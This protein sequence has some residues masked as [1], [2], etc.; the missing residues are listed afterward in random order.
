MAAVWLAWQYGKHGFKKLVAIKTILPKYAAEPGFQQMFLDECR[1]ASGIQHA[2][3]TQILDVG[4]AH[5]VLYMVMEW[6]D[7]DSLLKVE[8]ALRKTAP[9]FP[10]EVLLRIL[11]DA[12]LGLHA[13]H[14]LCDDRGRALGVVHRDV[15][16]Q[17]LLV[18]VEG[19]TKLI[20]FG[21]VKARDR[22]LR[23]TTSGLVKGKLQY[24]APEQALGQPVSR[25]A[26]IWAIGA[27]FYRVVKGRPAY[28][29]SNPMHTMKLVSSRRLPEPLTPQMGVHRAVL[30]VI[31]VALSPNPADRYPTALEMHRALEEAMVKAGQRVPAASVAAFLETHLGDRAAARRRAVLL[32]TEAASARR[33]L[34][35]V[36]KSPS[37]SSNGMIAVAQPS[38]DTPPPVSSDRPTQRID[39]RELHGSTVG[40]GRPELTAAPRDVFESIAGTP[41]SPTTWSPIRW[42]AI[43]FL[44]VGL[45]ALLLLRG[46][47]VD[48][49]TISKQVVQGETSANVRVAAGTPPPHPLGDAGTIAEP[50][51]EAAPVQSAEPPKT[52]TRAS[53]PSRSL[54]A[55]RGSTA[56]PAPPKETVRRDRTHVD[57]TSPSGAAPRKED[58]DGI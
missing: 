56:S 43:S 10:Q 30:D 20:D 9:T 28:D 12:C 19:V 17:N 5:G 13:A 7:G 3:V 46:V 48:P 33:M 15:S 22:L 57:S 47:G 54:A 25:H 53:E 50:T 35:S 26:D 36:V 16:P 29:A 31:D 39:V 40:T 55:S 14:E 11:S 32:A 4:E 27:V 23:E 2:N 42:A 6:V 8:R 21:I 45:A 58:E 24:M 37:P 38:T 49:S 34:A 1:I 52:M 18:S 51:T 44:L 41:A